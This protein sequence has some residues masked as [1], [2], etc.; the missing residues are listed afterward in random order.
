MDIVRNNWPEKYKLLLK[1]LKFKSSETERWEQI[2]H[3]MYF[4][5][6]EKL[7]LF[8]QQE[9]FMDKE[10]IL[11]TELD[12]EE[13]PLNQ[14]WSWDRILRSCFI[15]QADVLQGMYFFEDEFDDEILSRHFIFYESRTVHESSLSACIHSVMASRIG[16]QQKAYELY[17]RT[18]RLDLDDYNDEADQGCHITSM[19]GTW[20][21]IVEG[22]GGKRIKKGKL[23]LNPAIPEKWASYSFKIRFHGASLE[24]NVTRDIVMIKNQSEKTAQIILYGKE[25]SIK[26]KQEIV[27]KMVPDPSSFFSK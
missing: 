11:V 10:Q 9:G 16:E 18:A 25:Y 22:F 14:K 7:N 23:S 2:I 6:D 12:P 13:R 21:A 26:G 4:P 24:I 19:A 8:M 3:K 1:K 20:L 5:Y 15:K 17:L 27:T